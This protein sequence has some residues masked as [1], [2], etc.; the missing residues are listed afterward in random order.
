M[1][2]RPL[3]VL[4]S[5][6]SAAALVVGGVAV[7]SSA[8]HA[9]VGDDCPDPY[10]VSTLTPGQSVT[11][12][13]TVDGTIPEEFHGT[14]L[15]T[16]E[17][18]IAPGLDLPVFRMEGSSITKPDGSINAGIWA[19]MSGSPVYDDATGE[20]VG[21][22]SY[23]FSSSPSDIAGVTPATYMYDLQNPKYATVS[24]A[25]TTVPLST[26]ERAALSAASTDAAPVTGGHRLEP[27]KQVS[28]STASRANAFAKQSALLQSKAP[29]KS[30]GFVAGGSATTAAGDYPIVPGGNLATTFS[31]GEI[32]TA[33]VG[34]VTAICNGKVIGFGHP[35]EFS[36]KSSEAFHGAS[37]V[38]I[39]PSVAGSF[40]IANIGT[41]KGVVNQDRISGILGTIGQ[42]PQTAEVHSTTTGLGD[43]KEST[44]MVSQPF[45]LPFIAA[46]QAS[47]D[48]QSVLDQDSS[49]DAL[50]T[51]KIDYL[52][53]IAGVSTPQ[54]LQRTQRYSTSDAFPDQV[55]FDVA[56]DVESLLTNGFEKVRITKVDITSALLPDYRQFTP[57][58]AQYYTGGAWRNVASGA[59]IKAKPG[60][61]LKLRLKLK[62]ANPDTDVANTTADVRVLTSRGARGTGALRFSG[63]ASDPSSDGE[64]F[65]FPEEEF[66]PGSLDELLSFIKLQPRQ[67]NILRRL[68]Y[69]S[70]KYSYVRYSQVRAPGIVT[71]SF[72][73]RVAFLTP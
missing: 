41:V 4:A 68:T 62:A 56:S 12:L 16:I 27:T 3:R 59:T 47:S 73:F 61:T 7:T 8:A 66:S 43:T 32:T 13:T 5:L 72:G 25:R 15:R 54:T 52:R 45:A 14:Y 22:V 60:A 53:N 28:G 18:G 44:T 26:S 35:D 33:S 36:G 48:A 58:G 9:A 11:G 24:T 29:Y 1:K 63:Q 21:A 69:H 37:T 17:N 46:T 2:P 31:Y 34:T 49:G 57:Y 39:Q 20:L 23:G 67:D 40:K 71:G 42:V 55:S 19:G 6:T 50:M 30:S 38:V 70:S 10:D 51:W 64:D 65:G